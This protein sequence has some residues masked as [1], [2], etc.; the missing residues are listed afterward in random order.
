LEQRL[1]AALAAGASARGSVTPAENAGASSQPPEAETE[2]VEPDLAA[3]ATAVGVAVAPMTGGEEAPWPTDEAG[4]A[5]FAAAVR[6]P[7]AAS[8]TPV[9][10]D[11]SKVPLPALDTLVHRIPAEVREALE[12]LFR[13]KF[14]A[15]R[16]VPARFLNEG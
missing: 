6:E 11:E 14:T 12:D 3:S 7:P 16:R 9:A 1:G 8:V 5:G 4:E 2:A 13:A 10:V 15:V